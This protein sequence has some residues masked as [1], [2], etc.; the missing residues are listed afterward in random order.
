[1]TGNLFLKVAS[2]NTSYWSVRP[3]RMS[4]ASS[5]SML[6]TTPQ[7]GVHGPGDEI[8]GLLDSPPNLAGNLNRKGN[9]QFK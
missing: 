7:P 1:M 5:I 4:S 2:Y 8:N 3:D 9:N 6:T